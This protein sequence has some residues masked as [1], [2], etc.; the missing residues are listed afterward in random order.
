MRTLGLSWPLVVAIAA[1]FGSLCLL[2]IDRS[3]GDPDIYWHIVA[4]NWTLAHHAVPSTDIFSYSM[5]G[6]HWTRQEWLA[7][8]AMA[9]IFRAG[10]WVA[11]VMLG[12]ASFAL[13]LALLT[14]FLLARMEP[15]HALLFVSLSAFMMLNHLLV[16]P[17]L[18]TWPLLALW[19]GTLI[20]ACEAERDPPWWLLIVMVLWA[21]LHGGFTLGLVLGAGIGL[22][23]LVSAP[24]GT[25]SRVA[26]RWLSFVAAALAVSMLTPSGWGG[27]WFTV[28][29]L[30]MDYAKSVLDEWRSPDFHQLQALEIW[31]LLALAMA[32]SGRMR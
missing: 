30:R 7:E 3:L 23:A 21:N 22:D 19:V 12:A 26:A 32:W 20:D 6:A 24:R 17:H 18:L 2:P 8:L 29:L 15:I 28:R 4:G 27:I 5:P 16:R 13:T 25:R 11:M 10:G 9:L 1:L 14:R 31:L